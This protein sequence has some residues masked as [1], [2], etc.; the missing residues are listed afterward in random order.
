MIDSMTAHA[1]ANPSIDLSTRYLGLELPHPF[2]PGA[3]PMVD[4]I[5]TV[6]RLED[7]GAAAIVMRSLFEEQIEM[8][9]GRTLYDLSS[10]VNAFAE[11]RSFFPSPAEFRLGPDA[12]LNQIRLIK[13]TVRLPVIASLNG[14]SAS[15]W[16]DYAKLIETAGAD[17]L[18]LNVYQVAAN[19]AED[20]AAVERRT[21]D[22]VRSVRQAIRIPI[23]VKLSPFSSS[24]SHFAAEL[25]R[26]GAD[27]LVL[28]NRFYESD[29]DIEEL[30]TRSVLHLSSSSELLLRLQW[31]AIL[32]AQRGLDVAVSGGV[33][34]PHDAVK[35][36]MAG[37][38]AV[39]M[40]SALLRKG[41]QH[42]GE[43]V[44]GLAQFVEE[45]GYTSL[46]DM[47]G[48]MNLARCPDPA[49]FERGNYMRMLQSWRP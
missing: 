26:S 12:Y 30:E 36:V 39:Q 18:E 47:R 6:R 44:A 7:A 21:L 19:P 5:D 34:A 27:G 37:A 24:M 22:I 16:L 14:V 9:Q 35:A 17:A 13:E 15:G 32:S 4:E 25:E 40:V 20:G 3:S 28:F 8:E 38:C 1:A 46:S 45:H 42:L 10:H 41:P 2:M 43:M 49:A 23:A 11:A 29:I 33:H 31:L 48:C